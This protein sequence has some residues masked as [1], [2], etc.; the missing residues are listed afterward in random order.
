MMMMMMMKRT[1]NDVEDDVMRDA[2]VT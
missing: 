1:H 2:N